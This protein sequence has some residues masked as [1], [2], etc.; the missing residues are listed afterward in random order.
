VLPS[1]PREPVLA[2]SGS[3]KPKGERRAYLGGWVK[4]PV[5]D[6]DRLL[7]GAAIATST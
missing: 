7:P 5:Y 1:L 6:F 4:T 3:N 2:K